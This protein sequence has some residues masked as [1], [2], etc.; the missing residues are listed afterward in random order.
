LEVAIHARDLIY[1]R[2]RYFGPT[3]AQE[4]LSEIHGLKISRESVRQLMI[5]EGL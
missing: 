4:K 2:Y 3:L 1:E 5:T